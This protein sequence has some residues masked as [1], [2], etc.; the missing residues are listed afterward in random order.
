MVKE[1][2]M[3]LTNEKIQ[4]RLTDKFGETFFHFE[5]SYGMLSFDAPKNENLK[6]LQ[7]L[8]DDE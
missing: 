6:V 2:T 5:E 7:F 8:F 3:A 4:Q 1:A